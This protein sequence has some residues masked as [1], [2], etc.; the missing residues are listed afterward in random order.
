[1]NIEFTTCVAFTVGVIG[2]FYVKM[3]Y[4][5]YKKTAPKDQ[6]KL[7]CIYLVVALVSIILYFSIKLVNIPDRLGWVEEGVLNN[8]ALK[9]YLNN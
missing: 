3:M 1:M 5:Q 6:R 2:I 9:G 7:L 8:A 4:K